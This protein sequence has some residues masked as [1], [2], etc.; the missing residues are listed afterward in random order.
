[1]MK[2]IFYKM[3]L[4]FLIIILATTS[5]TIGEVQAA[6]Y[7]TFYNMAEKCH[8][9]LQKYTYNNRD[10]KKRKIE[11]NSDKQTDCSHY[12]SYTLYK[13]FQQYDLE[14]MMPTYQLKS[15][16]FANLAKYI[17]DGNFNNF[18]SSN[19]NVTSKE[20]IKELSKYFSKVS[21]NNV[22][23]G[24]ILIYN[25]KDSKSGHVEI[26]SKIANKNTKVLSCGNTY[27]I[28]AP[29]IVTSNRGLGNVDYILRV[30]TP[31]YKL[32]LDRA[33]RLAF[34]K[35]NKDLKITLTDESGVSSLAVY[36]YDT[37]TS[38]KFTEI[39]NYTNT[40]SSS[41]T[42]NNITVS[43]DL[44]VMKIQNDFFVAGEK[45]KI[46][47]VAKDGD[48]RKNEIK[49]TYILTKLEKQEEGNWYK[50]NVAPPQMTTTLTKDAIKAT[51]LR[52][53]IT[54]K[55]NS[56]ITSLEIRDR[57]DNNKTV[58]KEI[59]DDTN[60]QKE[61][62]YMLELSEYKEDNGYYRLTIIVSD[63]RVTRQEQIYL[64]TI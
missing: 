44:S 36:K 23:Q 34:D 50:I 58:V 9:D 18:N 60:K 49:V 12:V 53:E 17:R 22:K 30:K 8:K 19:S 40:L 32:Q 63:G 64:K 37:I 33:P 27:Q 4:T 52:K 59:Y 1:M 29:G 24:D 15:Y 11:L 25:S 38:N 31:Y 62:K 42:K 56:G 28:Q 3:I 21:Q 6:T 57:N 14:K 7:N 55:D 46:T 47:I 35:T 13:Y 16:D 51:E 54:F 2:R 48:N 45:T 61:L 39:I 10:G 41:K 20:D 26:Y 5:F 43:K